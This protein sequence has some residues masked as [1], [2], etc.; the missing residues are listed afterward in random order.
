MIVLAIS[1]ELCNSQNNNLDSLLITLPTTGEGRK[2]NPPS[3]SNA[4]IPFYPDP[5]IGEISS[6]SSTTT[7]CQWR[8]QRC[9]ACHQTY[10]K[11]CKNSA[12]FVDSGSKRFGRDVFGGS[13]RRERRTN[14]RGIDASFPSSSCH[15]RKNKKRET[16]LVHSKRRPDQWTKAKIQRRVV[17]SRGFYQSS[18]RLELTTARDVIDEPCRSRF[19]RLPRTGWSSRIPGRILRFVWKTIKFVQLRL[20]VRRSKGATP[21]LRIATIW[22]IGQNSARSSIRGTNHEA[23]VRPVD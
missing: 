2:S 23:V 18:R 12:I 7:G 13:W 16:H 15:D 14:G 9:P 22:D 3:Q 17:G 20:T 19:D 4:N 21:R 6:A 5:S 8:Y 1:I 10:Q 11:R